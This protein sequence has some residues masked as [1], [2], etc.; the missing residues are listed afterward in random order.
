MLK[1]ILVATDFSVNADHAWRFALDLARGGRTP[2][3]FCYTSRVLSPVLRHLRAARPRPA[4]R[5]SSQTP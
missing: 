3:C 2:S 4:N 5:G 1:R